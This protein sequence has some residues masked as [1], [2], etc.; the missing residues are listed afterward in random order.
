[1][2][3][4]DKSATQAIERSYNTPDIA[5]QRL[6][7]LKSLALNVGEHVI[8]IGCGTGFLVNEMAAVVGESGHLAGVD[9]SQDMLDVA[10]Q[11]CDT[12][13]QVTLRQGSAESLPFD[14]VSFDAASCTQ[15]L[16]YVPEVESAI[17]ELA[18]VLKPG[19]RLALIETDW[20]G[21]VLNSAHSSLTDRI[22]NAFDE[23]VPNANLP[24]RLIPM[25]KAA[26][27]GAIKVDAIP[28]INTSNSPANFSAGSLAWTAD[29]AVKSNK[30]TQDE[31]NQWLA[32]IDSK[33][34]AGEYFFCV[35]RF[36]FSAVKL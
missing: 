20:R 29:V 19:G 7:T 27:F 2:I 30:V 10:A 31:A 5:R 36:L 1:M 16:L 6:E 21:L 12:L 35:N 3:N 18:R 13:P 33:A 8:D 23:Y 22:F 32:D 9:F 14:D 17:A 4:Y 15:V 26:G 25:L 28:I 24:A 11:R 34:A